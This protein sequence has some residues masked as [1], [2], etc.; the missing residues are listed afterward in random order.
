MD[1]RGVPQH[2]PSKAAV[3]SATRVQS[4]ERTTAKY[5]SDRGDTMSEW[6]VASEEQGK[7]LHVRTQVHVLRA[8]N[9][10]GPN[11]HRGDDEQE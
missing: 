3:A 8:H 4:M 2:T 11:L 5:E 10:G 6:V 9:R 7:C 1:A